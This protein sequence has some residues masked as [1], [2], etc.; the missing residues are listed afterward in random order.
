MSTKDLKDVDVES[1]PLKNM[2]S[3][4]LRADGDNGEGHHIQILGTDSKSL[5]YRDEA[6][7]AHFGKR[8]QLKVSLHAKNKKKFFFLSFPSLSLPLINARVQFLMAEDRDA[9]VLYP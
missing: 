1:Y 6:E 9:S 7:L 3:I 2:N 8:Q 5:R 4:V